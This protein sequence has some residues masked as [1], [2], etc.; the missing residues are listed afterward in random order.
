MRYGEAY[1]FLRL[2][3]QAPWL[4]L[5]PLPLPSSGC[6]RPTVCK[7][8]WLPTAL[9]QLTGML[10]LVI[11]FRLEM[12]DF[13]LWGGKGGY[14]NTQKVCAGR[15]RGLIGRAITHSLRHKALK[16]IFKPKTVHFFGIGYEAIALVQMMPFSLFLNFGPG[17]LQAILVGIWSIEP[18]LVGG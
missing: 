14:W 7:L 2:Q 12:L 5:L 9:G 11:P 4:L 16:T 15:G 8:L 1:P 18:L 3:A 6:L 10:L 13:K 17:H